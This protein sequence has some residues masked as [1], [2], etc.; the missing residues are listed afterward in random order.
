MCRWSRPYWALNYSTRTLLAWEQQSSSIPLPTVLIREYH[1]INRQETQRIG[2]PFPN[3]RGTTDLSKGQYFD[4]SAKVK[5]I[6][7]SKRVKPVLSIRPST[8]DGG[9]VP[10][11]FN[12]SFLKFLSLGRDVESPLLLHYAVLEY[13]FLQLAV[14]LL[15]VLLLLPVQLARYHQI[16][17]LGQTAIRLHLIPDVLVYPVALRQLQPDL[18]LGVGCVDVLPSRP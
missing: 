16:P 15:Q 18:R 13:Q 9:F 10:F 14:A 3:S 8:F 2:R 11:L 7:E 1:C 12:P 6:Y 17:I 5:L 4:Y